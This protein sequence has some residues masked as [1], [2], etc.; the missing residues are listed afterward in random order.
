MSRVMI[1]CAALV[2]ACAAQLV[3]AAV[4]RA[5]SPKQVMAHH[6]AAVKKDDVDGV[7]EDYAVDAVL[8]TP[9][10]TFIGAAR[11]RTFFERLAAQHRDWKD[12]IVTQEVEQ[13][14]VVLQK[15]VKTG[16]VEVYVVRNGKIAFQ[17]L[18]P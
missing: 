11:I 15:N 1:A 18:P 7:M 6:I 10:G 8:V 5:A 16:K 12:Y 2:C 13:D 14:G 9:T 17:A 4:P 3:S